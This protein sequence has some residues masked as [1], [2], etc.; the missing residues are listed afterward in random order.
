MPHPSAKMGWCFKVTFLQ[1]KRNVFA[2]IEGEASVHFYNIT[3]MIL[4][5]M[6]WFDFQS[7]L[8]RLFVHDLRKILLF[9][10]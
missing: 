7:T 4:V 5:F 3:T 9:S 10:I 1:R 8:I 2:N 6:I